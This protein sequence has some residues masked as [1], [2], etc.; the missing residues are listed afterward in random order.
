MFDLDF[1][2]F[3]TGFYLIIFIKT[4][5]TYFTACKFYIIYFSLKYNFVT[6]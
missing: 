4:E 2:L 6:P 3:M 5:D 1:S